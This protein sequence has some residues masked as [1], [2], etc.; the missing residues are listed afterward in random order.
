VGCKKGFGR[1]AFV[2][3]LVLSLVLIM[4]ATVFA[5]ESK[6]EFGNNVV[7][8]ADVTLD[9]AVAIGGSVRVEGTVTGSVLTV[10]G[11]V[12]VSGQVNNDV[13]AV[14]G[15]VVLVPGARVEGDVVA[16]GGSIQRGENV[17]VG[18]KTTSVGFPGAGVFH[19]IPRLPVR[20]NNWQL[21]ALPF[22]PGLWFF[23]RQFIGFLSSLALGTIIL[24]FWPRNVENMVSMLQGNWSRL[25]VVGLLG[26]L[27]A[28]PLIIMVAIT[29][30]GI[31]L[32]LLLVL[33]LVAARFLAYTTVSVFVGRHLLERLL[34]Q[35]VSPIAELLAGLLLLLSVRFIPL[36]GWLV[37][38]SVAV[39]GLGVVL[40]TRCG[41]K[42][43]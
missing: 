30:I 1:I 23:G 39:I 21:F 25:V 16:I 11:D 14:G 12:Y 32:A 7:V 5:S 24:L 10:G 33:A 2:A 26:Y 8:P 38:L 17:Y 4:T 35:Q 22:G 28:L 41:S 40:D 34:P 37:G 43:P 13:A 29:I 20:L 18:G 42:N 36:V 19:Q 9:E 15:R 6:I 3:L 31:P 27:V